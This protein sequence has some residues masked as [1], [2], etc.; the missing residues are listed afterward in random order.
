MKIRSL[1]VLL[2]LALTMQLFSFTA[3]AEDAFLD[4]PTYWKMNQSSAAG[5]QLYEETE[6]TF[7]TYR[8]RALKDNE[9]LHRGVDVSEWQGKIDWEAVKND[10]VEFVFVRVGARGYGSSG[11]MMEDK[12][13][14]TNIQ[15]ALNAGL[16][17]GV[18]VFSQAITPE[19]AVEEAKFLL[20]RIGDYDIS[21]PLVFDYEYAG[22]PGRLEAAELTKKE[23]TDIWHA[24]EA[25]VEAKGYQAT[26]Y[27]NKYFL[28]N[29]LNAKDIDSVWLAHYIVETDYTGNYEFWQFTSSGKVKGIAG[30]A[31]LDFWFMDFLFRDVTLTHWAYESICYAYER[32]Y[33]NG[34]DKN[35]FAPDTNATRGQMITM[36]YRMMGSPAVTQPSTFLDLTESYYMDAIAWGQQNG[37]VN[38]RSET[39][40]DPD[41]YVS[42]QEFVT[43]LYRLAGKPE[44]TYSLSAFMDAEDISEYAVS[45]MSWAVEQGIIRGESDTLLNPEGYATRAQIATIL[46]RY[47]QIRN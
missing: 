24:F 28:N 17:V 26:L 14:K 29:Q 11:K 37:I 46:M 33:V 32:G 22:N 34:L 9:S 38:G 5:D 31:D 18:Y 25:A 42:R 20:D 2:A 4:D 7:D 47:D 41:A 39:R 12:Y 10:G 40:Y 30:K 27:A 23:A 19:E 43:M 35:S 45:S 15:G 21:L 16:K 13:Y 6:V 36:L 8:P 3:V 44:S 1:L